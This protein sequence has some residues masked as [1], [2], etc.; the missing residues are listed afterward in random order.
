METEGLKEDEEST[1]DVDDEDLVSTK[2]D[3]E[4]GETLDSTVSTVIQEWNTDDSFSTTTSSVIEQPLNIT[5]SSGESSDEKVSCTCIL[6]GLPLCGTVK[7]LTEI[8]ISEYLSNN[9]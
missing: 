8:S 4:L 7:S 1:G 6:E 2:Y 9:F 5:N 3:K